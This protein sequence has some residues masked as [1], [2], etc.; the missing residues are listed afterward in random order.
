[1]SAPTWH[2]Q[3][4]KR[5]TTPTCPC[6]SGPCGHCSAGKHDDCLWVRDPAEAAR[7][8]ARPPYIWLI[9]RKGYVP[10]FPTSRGE[11][12]RV[13]LDG[14]GTHIWRCPCHLNGHGDAMPQQALDLFGEVTA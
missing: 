6:Q 2:P 12:A 14:A 7:M 13:Y 9:D 11:V 1:M 5:V 8:D 10:T 4:G 3:T